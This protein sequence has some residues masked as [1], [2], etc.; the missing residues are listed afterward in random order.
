M[1]EDIKLSLIYLLILLG[2][3]LKSFEG[4]QYTRYEKETI[5]T[6]KQSFISVRKTTFCLIFTTG[7]QIHYKN[8]LVVGTKKEW[9]EKGEIKF[10][11]EFKDGV[12]KY[13]KTLSSK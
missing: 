11:G 3:E 8:K 9:Y 7:Q 4:S 13:L 12:N 5:H 10:K 6:S 1:C 2:F